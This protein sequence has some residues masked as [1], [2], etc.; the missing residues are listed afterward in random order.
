MI[1]PSAQALRSLPNDAQRTAEIVDAEIVDN[2]PPDPTQALWSALLAAPAA[3]LSLPDL[4]NVTGLGRSWVYARLHEHAN[5][6]RA[7]QVTRGRW[8][9]HVPR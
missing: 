1:K 5:A 2:D 8:R 6:G 7:Y 9:A 3:G 4:M